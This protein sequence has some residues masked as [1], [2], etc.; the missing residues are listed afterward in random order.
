[1]KIKYLPRILLVFICL[2]SVLST[3]GVYATWKYAAPATTENSF[4]VKM[5]LKQTVYITDA[6]YDTGNGSINIKGYTETN[7]NSVVTLTSSNTS[8]VTVKI[9][10]YNNANKTY[11]FNAIKYLPENYSNTNIICTLPVL[12]HGDEIA[13]GESLEFSA[14]YKFKNNKAS[15]NTVLNSVINFEFLPLDELPAEEE[16]AVSGALGQ[17]KNIINNITTADS[18]ETLINQMDDY[19]NNDRNDNSYIGNVGGASDEDTAL[20]EDLFQGNLT[21]NINGVET[22]VTILIKRENI[23]GNINTGDAEGNE[24]SIYMTT[25]DL[26]KDSW[27]G[28]E[29]APVYVAVFSSDD[30]GENWY[31]L[32]EMYEGTATIKRYDGWMGSGSFDTDT[33]RSTT[34]VSLQNI[35][36]SL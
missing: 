34:N 32:G 16:I 25:D 21:I 30:D 22:E 35:I 31:Q 18:F 8:S 24:M 4:A 12:K 2:I 13:P 33:W 6:L 19:A 26:Q 23:D 1:M 11:A 3:A 20:L 17:F 7:F 10:V 5:D 36:T 9:T 15:T 27:F 29:K 28:T 14:V